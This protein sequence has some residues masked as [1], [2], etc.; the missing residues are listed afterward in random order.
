MMGVPG[1][2]M[3]VGKI[4]V[5]LSLKLASGWTLN[6]DLMSSLALPVMYSFDY[7]YE[8]VKLR[9]ISCK[10]MQPLALHLS[11]SELRFQFLYG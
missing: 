4:F 10:V 5:R 2:I 11:L 8:Y 6:I 1:M 9:N 7:V 3:T